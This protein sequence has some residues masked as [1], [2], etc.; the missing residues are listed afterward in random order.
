M[1]GFPNT[2]SKS[3]KVENTNS[4]SEATMKSSSSLDVSLPEAYIALNKSK[5]SLL[6]LKADQ[7]DI[8]IKELE[9]GLCHVRKSPRVFPNPQSRTEGPQ[10]TCSSPAKESS[11]A[12]A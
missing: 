10:A 1:L 5:A 8:K 12:V 9:R 6:K 7:L 11:D 3:E 2:N 4:P